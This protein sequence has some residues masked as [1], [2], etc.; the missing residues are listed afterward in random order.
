MDKSLKKRTA[1]ALALAAA[2]A[3]SAAMAAGPEFRITQN[4]VEGQYIVVLKENVAALATERGRGMAVA[5]MARQMAGQHGAQVRRSFTHALRG[6]VVRADDRALARLLADD[7]I[8]YVE[9]DGYVSIDATQSPATW[10]ID[11]VDQRD[12]PLGNS[13]T[14]NTSASGVHAYIIDTGVLL[15]HVEFSGRIGNGFDAVTSGGNANDCN[16]HGTHVAGTVGGTTYGVAKGVTIHPVRV[17]G[18]N[19]SGTNSGVIAGM[20]WVAANHV[21]PAVANMSLGGGASTATDDAVARMTS[22][23]VIVAVAAGND[24]A[25]ACNY[26]PARAPS[27]I[28]VGSTTTTDARSSFSNFGTCLDIFAPGS[29]ITSAWYTGSTATNTISGTSMASPHVAGVAALYLADNPTATPSAVTAALNDA[30]TPNKVTSPG[31]GSPN[32]LLYSFF[33]AP[34]PVDT[35]A[36]S[37]PAGLGAT[38]SGSSQINLSWSAS[39]DTGGSGLAGYRIERCAGAGCSNFAEIATTSS[40]TYSNTG[41][42]GDTSYSYRIRA[43]DGAGNSSGYS[44]TA[45]AAT[46]AATNVLQ[47]GVPVSGLGASTGNGLAYTMNVPAGA[48]NLSFAMSGGTGDADLYVRFGS[49]P[50]TSTYDCRPYRAGNAET[51][52]FATPQAGTYHVLVRAYSTFSGVSLTGSF[53]AGG[54][55]GGTQTYTNASDFTIG[56]NSTINSTIAV[57]GRT[58]NAP[59][60]SQVKVD[61]KHTYTG[62]LKVDLVAPDGTVYVLHNRTGGSAD[63]INT[64]YTVNLSSEALNGTWTLRVNDN[65]NQDTGFLDSWS[66]TF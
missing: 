30:A 51:C 28:T 27:A 42:A 33:G 37:V 38:A 19:G 52:T 34:P 22:A 4:P 5:D 56:D 40:T 11:R 23:G 12:L 57:S 59:G 63:N 21:K 10:G 44:N 9:E 41:L 8:A 29:S 58:G 66:L 50:T 47:N 15:S 7:R 17:L 16:G 32:R 36:P 43:Y 35:I 3:S 64:T 25:N 45:S 55:G 60:G 31:T 14:Y 18:C 54:G 39:T 65:A 20:D 2:L 61:I 13:Y 26:S 24:N 46:G 1:L 48:S 6:F 53:T 49:A 62:D